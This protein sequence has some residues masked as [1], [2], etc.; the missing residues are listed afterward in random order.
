MVLNDLI[1]YLERLS[2][3]EAAAKLQRQGDLKLTPPAGEVVL[4]G[5]PNQQDAT[6]QDI[7]HSEWFHAWEEEFRGSTLE[8]LEAKLSLN[9]QALRT[10]TMPM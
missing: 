5:G 8:N 7:E 10:A 3:S 2:T 9:V 4:L 6:S 1:Q